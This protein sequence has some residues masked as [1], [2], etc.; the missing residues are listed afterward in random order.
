MPTLH[1]IAMERAIQ[2]CPPVQ[3]SL[4]LPG[5]KSYT[6]RALVAA[7]LATGE[8]IL[9]NAL[10]AEDTELTAQALAQLGAGIDWQG[11]TIRVRGAGGRWRPVAEPIYLGNSGTSM[12]FFTALVALGQGTYVLT[13]TRAP[14]PAAPGRTA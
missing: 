1:K 2:P 10:K 11:D 5:S 7:A 14:L 3:A 8:S 9:T 13:G 12:R 6:H 4:T